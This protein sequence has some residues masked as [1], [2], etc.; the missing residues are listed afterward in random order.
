MTLQ[1]TERKGGP[2][3]E[4][5]PKLKFTRVSQDPGPNYEHLKQLEPMVG[6]WLI[7]MELPETIPGIAEAGDALKL[8]VTTE[9]G[10]KKNILQTNFDIIVN[11]KMLKTDTRIL[12]WDGEN[13]QILE[14]GFDTLGGRTKILTKPEKENTFVGKAH[15]V[16]PE[17]AVEESTIR[18]TFVDEDTIEF[19]IVDMTVDGVEEPVPPGTITAK[20]VK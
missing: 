2:W 9:W 7:E 13:E 5:G 16:T 6:N 15:A 12:G 19:Q 10:P 8:M 1:A 20:R 4:T 11:G 14:Y 17:G 3:D 18:M